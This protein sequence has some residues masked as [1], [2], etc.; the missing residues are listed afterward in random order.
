MIDTEPYFPIYKKSD[1]HRTFLYALTSF[2]G[3]TIADGEFDKILP[4]D[5]CVEAFAKIQSCPRLLT[6]HKEFN[7]MIIDFTEFISATYFQNNIFPDEVEVLFM[8][9]NTQI[10]TKQ[11]HIIRAQSFDPKM[12]DC[13]M[14]YKPP[15]ERLVVDPS[16]NG[17]W[18]YETIPGKHV[19]TIKIKPIDLTPNFSSLL[20]EPYLNVNLNSEQ[21]GN[22]VIRN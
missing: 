7:S 4:I 9:S 10:I 8:D 1:I 16:G 5:Q 6:T 20:P 19:A 12:Y 3:T 21:K 2:L 13:E 18:H 14:I 11:K 15:R 22:P 17:D